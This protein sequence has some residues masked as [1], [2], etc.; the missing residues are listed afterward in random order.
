MQTSSSFA[1]NLQAIY[2]KLQNWRRKVMQGNVV[3]FEKLSSVVEKTEERDESLKTFIIGYLHSLEIEFQWYFPELK[4]EETALMRNPFTTSLVIANILDEL[5]DQFCDLWND[6]SSRDIFHEMPL[7]S[8]L[9]S[10]S[11]I[12]PTTVW[13][14]FSNIAFVCHNTSLREWFFSSSSH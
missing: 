5:Q 7:S 2:S 6:S 8:I 4:E 14:S 3:M 9:V 10:C 12:I 1:T 13:T 11:W